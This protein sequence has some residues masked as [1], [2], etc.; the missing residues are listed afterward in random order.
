MQI[1]NNFIDMKEKKITKD[2]KIY[3]VYSGD[4]DGIPTKWITYTKWNKKIIISMSNEG[5]TYKDVKGNEI[6]VYEYDEPQYNEW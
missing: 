2:K 6:L 3:Y 4:C 1:N 5:L